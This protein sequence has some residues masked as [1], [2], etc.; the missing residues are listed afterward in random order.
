[1]RLLRRKSSEPSTARVGERGAAPSGKL[2]KEL[3]KAQ[4]VRAPATIPAI[5]MTSVGAANW[6]VLCPDC[7]RVIMSSALVRPAA[8]RLC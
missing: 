2:M 4:F 5:A 7:C 6:V 1:M 8:L 3:L